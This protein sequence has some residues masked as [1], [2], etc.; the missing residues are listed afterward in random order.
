MI[1]KPGY[2]LLYVP[3]VELLESSDVS[4]EWTLA[5]LP[6]E[7][8][9]RLRVDTHKIGMPGYPFTG[10]DTTNRLAALFVQIAVHARN[11]QLMAESADHIINV[12]ERYHI[13]ITPVGDVYYLAR[14]T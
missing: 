3:I 5:I 12:H 11:P 13:A 14:T 4:E 9:R 7:P 1:A 10:R 6:L 8:T 2:P